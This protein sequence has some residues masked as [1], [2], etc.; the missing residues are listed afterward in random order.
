MFSPIYALAYALDYVVAE[1]RRNSTSR[2]LVVPV[3]HRF[4]TASG[5]RERHHF[6]KASAALVPHRSP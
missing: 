2:A 6:S 1:V 3:P 4:S 5:E